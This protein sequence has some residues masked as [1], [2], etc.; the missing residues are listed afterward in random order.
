MESNSVSRLHIPTILC[1]EAPTAAQPSTD[2]SPILN[3]DT[4][5]PF[6]PILDQEPKD[7][8]LDAVESETPIASHTVVL[9]EDNESSSS[10]GDSVSVHT[11]AHVLGKEALVKKFVEQDAPVPWDETH[12]GVEWTKKWNDS[13][14]IPSSKVLT[15]HIAKADELMTSTDFKTQLKITALTTKS[16]QG[17]QSETQAKVDKLQESANKL[18]MQIKLDKTRIIRPTLEKVE[19][20]EKAQE[21][22]QAQISEVLANQASQQA[23]LNNIQSLVELL[24]LLLLSDDAKKG[25]K[26]V[27][28]KC[29]NDQILKK[30]DD[31]AD[32]QGNP[33]KGRGQV[34]GKEHNNKVSSRK[35][36]TD[37]SRSSIQKKTSTEAAQTQNLIASADTQNMISSSDEQSLMTKPDVVIQGGS[38]DS[39][40][41]MQTLKLKGK[42]T[43]VYYKDPKIQTLDEEIARRLFL[44]H[45][46]GKDLEN[47]KEEEARFKAEKTNLKPKAFVAKKPPRPNVKGIVIKEKSHTEASK[48]KTRSQSEID[49]KD[50]GKG[51]VDEPIKPL[52]MKIPQILIK[53]AQ[54][55]QSEELQATTEITSSDKFIKTS[56]SDYAQV[57]LDK[58]EVAD[59]KKLMWKNVKPSDL[60]KS[61]LLSTFMTIGLNAREPRDRA[62]LDFDEAK[63]KTGVEV[64]TRDLFLLTD[65]PL[66]D[67]TQKH[68]DKVISVQVVL[69]VHDKHNVKENLILFLEDGRTY[70][71]SESDVLNNSLKELQF[72]YYLLEVKSDITRRWS[73]FILKTIRD[74]ARIFCSRVTEFIRSI[75][76]DDGSE[77]PMKKNSA[78]LEVLLNEK[79]MCYNEDSSHLRVIRLNDGLERN[80]ISALRTAIYQIGS[81]DEEMKQVKATISQVLRI[82][83][84]K[85]ISSFVKNHYGFRLTQ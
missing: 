44:K 23:Q 24:L 80:H 28:S 13:D 46:S 73:N 58:M 48:P 52:E 76:E 50:K 15:E 41:F 2:N 45:N 66:K 75:V 72:F 20:I 59:K 47:L 62:G 27:K 51:K 79:C 34:Q 55:I 11:T 82:K 14:F 85:L 83:E 9:S 61:Q 42:Q 16:L 63:I 6:T 53:P 77:T 43:T 32:D 70:Q 3:A 54:V 26:I 33:S 36:I 25:E 68:L 31:E 39:Q 81:Q 64:A 60:K 29:S 21:K 7:Q 65:K 19:V 38:Q 67:V 17:L 57:D 56:T 22:Q 49:P 18:D 12:R 40:K 1:L 84:E 37:A 10:S 69:D 35:L 5:I 4:E 30:K 78:K 74:K 8:N 71:M